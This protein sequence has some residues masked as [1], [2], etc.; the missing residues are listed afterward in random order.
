MVGVPE[1]QREVERDETVQHG[2]EKDQGRP[3]CSLSLH[4]RGLRER[5]RETFPGAVVTGQG[6]SGFKLKEG[7]F[8]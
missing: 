2:E 7:R 1:L 6:G 3:Y 8:R 5:W 4:K